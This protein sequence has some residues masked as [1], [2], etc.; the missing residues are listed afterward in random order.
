MKKVIIGIVAK[1][2]FENSIRPNTFIRSELKQAIFDNNAIAI[3]ILPTNV[4]KVFANNSDY[5]SLSQKE[6]EDLITQLNLCDG[7]IL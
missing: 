4:K 6:K 2:N 3:G 5:I 1:N 7:I